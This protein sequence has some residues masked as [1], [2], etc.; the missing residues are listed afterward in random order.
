MI[1]FS[2][3][4]NAFYDDKLEGRY[5][6]EGNWPDDPVEISDEDHKKY[7]GEP[8]AGKVL[9]VSANAPAW[10]DDTTNRTPQ[11]VTMRQARLAL[12][13]TGRLADVETAIAGMSE[14]DKTAASIEWEYSQT[15]ERG[16]PFVSVLAGL[17]SLTETDLDDLF[18]LAATL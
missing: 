8:P 3:T 5:V 14:P 10:V 7:S 15:V 16:R 11:V 4:K 12:L 1:L 18:T 9:G 17:L 2:A 13:S 6:E